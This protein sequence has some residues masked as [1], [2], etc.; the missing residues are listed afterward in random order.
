MNGINKLESEFKEI[1]KKLNKDSPS[2]MIYHYTDFSGLS[3]IIKERKLRFSDYRH[4]NDPTEI[5]FGINIILEQLV[6]SNINRNYL[7]MAIKILN[8]ISNLLNLY[9]A[10]FSLEIDKLSLWRYYASN[11]TGFAIGFNELF[12]KTEDNEKY[13]LDKGIICKIKYGEETASSIVNEFINTYLNHEHPESEDDFKLFLA[14]LAHLISILPLI[15]D[16]S[17]SDENEFRIFYQEGKLLLD[18][19]NEKPFYFDNDRREFIP[20]K[21]V[22]IPFVSISHQKKPVLTEKFCEDMISEIWV[23]PCCNFL[24][25]RS[26]IIDLLK[27]NGYSIEKIDIKECLLPYRFG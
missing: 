26:Y 1:H 22:N 12:Y 10:C 9:I 24:E 11:G 23:G 13:E 5:N 14:L 6:K 21:N 3:G 15:K 16:K 27:E 2:G 17:F 4:F 7:N 25:A 19:I 8:D 18:P 20:I